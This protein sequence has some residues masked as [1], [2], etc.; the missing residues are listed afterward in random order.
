[1]KKKF[2]WN[3]ARICEIVF[4][5]DGVLFTAVGILCGLFIDEIAASPNSRGNVYILP[6]V[7]TALGIVFLL[8]TAVLLTLTAKRKQER[9]RLME[10][11]RYINA[12]VTEV[13][14]NLYVQIN[15]RHPY[16]VVCQGT[17]PY[18][19]QQRTFRSADTTEDPSHLRGKYLRVFLDPQNPKK[20]YVELGRE[21]RA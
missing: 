12:L 18:T 6:W 3:A 11:G 21:D 5:I 19:G 1:M 16:Y 7:F 2:E 15:H 4:G 8:M 20:Y 10:S 17:D 14:Q 13:S 9:R